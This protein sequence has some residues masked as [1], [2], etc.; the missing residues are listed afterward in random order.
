MIRKTLVVVAV[1]ALVGV[2]A[3]S[4]LA[5]GGPGKGAGAPS[6]AGTNCNG[7]G[8]VGVQ[9][10]P[11]AAAAT[12]LGLNQTELRTQKAAGKTLAQIAVAQGKTVAGLKAAMIA[13]VE[14]NLDAAVAAGRITAAQAADRLA[15]MQ[16]RI[17][18]LVNATAPGGMGFGFRGGR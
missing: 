15:D 8:P 9:G 2:G 14:K 13:G 11:M 5:A 1:A 17:D 16:D 4:A 12:Y 18:A 3:G 6:W 10:A 7:A